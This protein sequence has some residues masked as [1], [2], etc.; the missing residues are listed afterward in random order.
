MPATISTDAEL[1]LVTAC[2]RHVREHL[3]RIDA[4]VGVEVG[5]AY[6]ASIAE[7]LLAR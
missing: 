7:L 1:E 3:D 6:R 2:L 5:D 4:E